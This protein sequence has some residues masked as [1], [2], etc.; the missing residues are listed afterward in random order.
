MVLTSLIRSL[1]A[2]QAQLGARHRTQVADT[3]P[4]WVSPSAPLGI[5]EARAVAR[6]L[7]SLQGKTI[8]RT[9]SSRDKSKSK[10]KE[11]PAESLLGAF[12]KHA[13]PVLGAY[14]NML[15]DPLVAVDSSIREALAPGLYALCDAMGERGRDALMVSG[16]DA[17]GRTVFKALWRDYDKQRYVGKG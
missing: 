8:P 4:W 1:R 15:V 2:P 16:C 14:I 10:E 3:L 6:L 11:R 7:T 9:F 13:A 12:S 17:A 5:P